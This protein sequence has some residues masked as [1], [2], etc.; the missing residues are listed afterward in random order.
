MTEFKNALLST[1]GPGDVEIIRPFL[2]LRS[3]GLREAFERPGDEL[4][5]AYF[6]ESG[7]ISVVADSGPR[8]EAEVGI[9]GVEGLS[10]AS[11]LLGIR[12][13]SFHVYA[14]SIGS[15]YQIATAD[16]IACAAGSPSLSSHLLKFIHLFSVQIAGTALV[17]SV[18]TV[19]MR[20]AR[21][22]LMARDRIRGPELA[23]THEFLALMLGVRRPG[24]TVAIQMLESRNLIRARR[25]SIAIRDRDGLIAAAAGF[26]GAPEAEYLRVYGF[27]GR[28]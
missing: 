14:Q 7:I 22:L 10:G 8:R 25:G 23:L 20:L 5:D 13:S 21:W 2:K 1:L 26:Y 11:A 12:R 6:V 18:G 3:Y 17:N 27:S 15:S 9:V 19:E 28:A 16:L 4:T 24:V